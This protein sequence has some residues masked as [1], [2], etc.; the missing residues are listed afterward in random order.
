MSDHIMNRPLD[1]GAY[2]NW[3]HTF[4][5]NTERPSA[6]QKPTYEEVVRMYRAV[7]AG[8]IKLVP[9]AAIE[10]FLRFEKRLP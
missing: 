5:A 7:L 3:D 1:L 10:G 4:G 6:P 2:D 8:I 9:P